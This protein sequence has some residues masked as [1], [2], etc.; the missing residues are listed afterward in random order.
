PQPPATTVVDELLSVEH[1]NDH[2]SRPRDGDRS[3]GTNAV[4]VER[5]YFWRRVRAISALPH[6]S[7]LVRYRLVKV[8][9][10][11]TSPPRAPQTP[12]SALV[13]T[14]LRTTHCI[15]LTHH[16]RSHNDLRRRLGYPPN[17]PAGSLLQDHRARFQRRP[18]VPRWTRH[19]LRD[20][21]HH[22]AQ[23]ADTRYGYRRQR[24]VPRWRLRTGTGQDRRSHGSHCRRGHD[25]DG[26]S[27]ELPT[28]AGRGPRPQRL[29]RVHPRRPNDLARRDGP[30]G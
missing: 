8:M 2:G 23:S 17:I 15:L 5:R 25:R 20:G 4:N 13:L 24:A 1:E 21:V 29:R 11:V 26:T 10:P 3:N 6:I 22:R 30:R 12:T 16:L 7:R 9:I 19:L 18:G 14:T 28:R 27:R